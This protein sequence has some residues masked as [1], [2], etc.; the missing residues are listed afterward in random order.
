MVS[1]L[2]KRYII[3]K[4]F[5]L[6]QIHLPVVRVSLYRIRKTQSGIFFGSISSPI[7]GFILSTNLPSIEFIDIWISWI[8]VNGSLESTL[9][10]SLVAKFKA[11]NKFLRQDFI[12]RYS[13]S[14]FVLTS[15]FM[16]NIT[17]NDDII[18]GSVVLQGYK[19]KKWQIEL[20]NRF[21]ITRLKQ[22]QRDVKSLPLFWLSKKA[23]WIKLI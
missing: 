23:F 1:K 7:H 8:C 13:I 16:Q 21:K 5:N 9:K 10:L 20:G 12:I 11:I 15:V 22:K 6:G 4:S 19:G 17:H 2:Y 14:R 3:E 18:C